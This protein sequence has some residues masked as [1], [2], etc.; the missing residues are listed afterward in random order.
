MVE[1]IINAPYQISKIPFLES[2][3]VNDYSSTICTPQKFLPKILIF[4][5]WRVRPTLKSLS[6]PD[7]YEASIN[8]LKNIYRIVLGKASMVCDALH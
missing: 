6:K 2:L 7:M 3:L 8:F 4:G 5:R 1:P